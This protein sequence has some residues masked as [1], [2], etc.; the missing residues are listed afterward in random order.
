MRKL[1]LPAFLLISIC[2][3]AQIISGIDSSDVIRIENTL[4]ADDMQ[5]RQVFTPGIEKAAAFHKR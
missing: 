4:A 5:G 1:I 2:A 3:Q